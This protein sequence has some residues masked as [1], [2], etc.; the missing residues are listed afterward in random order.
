MRLRDRYVKFTTDLTSLTRKAKPRESCGHQ[1]SS[2]RGGTSLWLS[3]IVSGLVACSGT[4][5]WAFDIYCNHLLLGP[6]PSMEGHFTFPPPQPCLSLIDR[7]VISLS[8]S[9]YSKDI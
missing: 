7:A 2:N 6:P 5:A 4:V 3:L 1:P 8:K 9:A